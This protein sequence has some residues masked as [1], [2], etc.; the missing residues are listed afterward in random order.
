CPNGWILIWSDYDEASAT[1]KDYQWVH[2]FVHKYQ[3]SKHNGQ[4]VYLPV[5]QY[6]TT[7]TVKTLTVYN[8]SIVGSDN[9]TSD[10][11]QKDIVLRYVLAW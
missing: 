2:T 7:M 4:E 11:N 6:Y 1:A 3:G 10:S 5:P 8:D 9:N